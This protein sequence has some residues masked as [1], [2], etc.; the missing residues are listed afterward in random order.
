MKA[1]AAP[2]LTAGYAFGPFRLDLQLQELRRGAEPVPLTPKAFDTLRVLVEAEGAVVPKEELLAL[3][4]RD[5]FVEESVLSQ[6]VYTLRKVLAEGDEGRS[7]ILT[8][9][10]RGYRFAMPVERLS[11]EHAI[12][13]AAVAAVMEKSSRG[14]A[15]AIG[16]TTPALAGAA[17]VTQVTAM[18]G[19]GGLGAGSGMTSAAATPWTGPERRAATRTPPGE[20]RRRPL[21]LA[22]LG[23]LLLLAAFLAIAARWRGEPAPPGALRVGSLAVL[24]FL[25]LNPPADGDVLGLAMA[26]ALITRLSELEPLVVRPTSAVQELREAPRDALGI[27][28]RLGVDAVMDGSLQRSGDRLRVSV[29]LLR[30]DDG[31]PLWARSFETVY[32]DPFAVQDAISEQVADALSLELSGRRPH[33]PGNRGT[34]DAEAYQE[35]VRGRYFWNRRTEA[36]LKKAMTHFEGAL[37]RDPAFAAA[38]AGIADC[39]VLLPLYGN[40]PPRDAFPRAIAKAREALRLDPDLAEAHTTLAYARFLYDW[41][42]ADA[43]EGF[44]RAQRLDPGYP[45]APQWYAYLLSATGRHDEAIANAR[46]AQ[47]LDPLSMVINADLGFVLYFARQDD[48]A[49]AQFERTLELDPRFPYTHFGLAFALDAAGRHDEAVKEA[50]QAVELSGDS[51]VMRGA[52]GYTLA[53]AGHMEEARAVR[54]ALA[55]R[56]ETTRVQPAAFALVDVGLGDHAAALDELETA[57]RDRSR[58]VVLMGVLRAFDPLRGE[59][60]WADLTRR[61]GLPAAVAAPLPAPAAAAAAAK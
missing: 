15:A 13:E 4:W 9:P 47:R 54:A 53:R 31:R 58:F 59:P 38:H 5:R 24:P 43:E 12:G 48:E 6:N 44:R 39:W 40:T 37:A 35:Y 42:W 21:L 23:A 34:A 52:L 27:G 61:V 25:S 46:L 26:D 45:T 56:N 8:V 19:G 16:A 18:S 50:R 22:G 32:T 7:Y 14:A 28:R 10:R 17:S 11:G 60:R 2:P 57:Y 36:D 55:K 3:V 20:S 51:S 41:S 30:V 29:R 1:S 33:R 49:I